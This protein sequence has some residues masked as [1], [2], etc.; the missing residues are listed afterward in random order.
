[1]SLY[2]CT[3]AGHL[4]SEL[5]SDRQEEQSPHKVL[6]ARLEHRQSAVQLVVSEQELNASETGMLATNEYTY[7]VGFCSCIFL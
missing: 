1:M 6:P 4:Q 5:E 3:A 2:T 7:T